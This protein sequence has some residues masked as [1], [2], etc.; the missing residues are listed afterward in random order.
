M[1]STDGYFIYEGQ[2]VNW[3]MQGYGRF[4][5]NGYY[6][7]GE[8]KDDKYHGQGSYVFSNGTIKKGTFINGGFDK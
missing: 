8:W 2:F 1:I 6:Y 4:I 7:I 3:K 5:G